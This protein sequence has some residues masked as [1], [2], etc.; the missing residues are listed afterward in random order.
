MRVNMTSG[1]NK[2]LVFG[3]LFGMSHTTPKGTVETGGGG[4]GVFFS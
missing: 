4:R 3:E 1:R 2:P